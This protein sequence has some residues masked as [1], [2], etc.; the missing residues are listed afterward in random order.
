[1]AMDVLCMCFLLVGASPKE[2]KKKKTYTISGKKGKRKRHTLF[3][4]VTS[5]AI[6]D[7]LL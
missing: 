7:I 1:M 3:W 5:Y 4:N 2:R 6:D